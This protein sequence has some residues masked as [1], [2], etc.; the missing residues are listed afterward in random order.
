MEVDE[1]IRLFREFIEQNYHAQLLEAVRKGQ[2]S[3][4][5][6]FSLLIKFNTSLL[7]NY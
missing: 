6:D 7:M 5:L 3:L 4:V 2:K 1:Q